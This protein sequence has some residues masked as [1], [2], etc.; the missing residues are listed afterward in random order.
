M[1][2]KIELPKAAVGYWPYREAFA[3]AVFW[4]GETD[5]DYHAELARSARTSCDNHQTF[6]VFDPVCCLQLYVTFHDLKMFVGTKVRAMEGG[7]LPPM[8]GA[9]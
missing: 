5:H 7:K 8:K 2:L 6:E 1:K 9:P 3:D 4:L